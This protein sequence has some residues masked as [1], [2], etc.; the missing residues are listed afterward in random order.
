MSVPTVSFLSALAVAETPAGPDLTRYLLICAGM[1]SAVALLGFVLQRAVSG[2]LAGRAAKRSLRVVDVLPLGGK[3]RLAVVRV[4][5]RTFVLG[6]GDK[7]VNLVSELDGASAG[8]A[9]AEA[10]SAAKAPRSGAAWKRAFEEIRSRV[11][12][13]KPKPQPAP[14]KTVER[15]KSV[16]PAPAKKTTRKVLGGRGL[17]G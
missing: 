10:T 11:A 5:D 2:T 16:V 17:L 13:G 7:S 9:L 15:A 4:Y 8:E 14:A 6:L 1:V 12:E 3:K